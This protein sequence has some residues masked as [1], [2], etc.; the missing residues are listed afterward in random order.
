MST[1]F[2]IL[3]AA[4]LVAALLYPG[5][6]EAQDA[7]QR[8]MYEL[9]S[10]TVTVPSES[11]PLYGSAVALYEAGEWEQAAKMFRDAAEGMP[12]NHANSYLPYDQSA[13]LYFYAGDFS[14]ARNMM[15]HAAAVAEATGDMVSAA[16]RHVDAAF[17]AVWEGYPGKRREHV[18]AAEAYAAEY[19]FD[20]EDMDRIG[21]LT[22]GVESLPVADE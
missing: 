16:Y 12:E 10:I 14:D 19:A 7:V 6:M 1:E 8:P 17:I 22:R 21:A 2:R 18:K 9:P 13:R 5:S 11:D 4:A 15:E 3:S 20:Q